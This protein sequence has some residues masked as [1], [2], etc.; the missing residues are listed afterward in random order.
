LAGTVPPPVTQFSGKT[1]IIQR[2]RSAV[3]GSSAVFLV[4]QWN[5][6]LAVEVGLASE[7]QIQ[8]A[9]NLTKKMILALGLVWVGAVNAQTAATSGSS[10]SGL[11]GQRYAELGFGVHD[12]KFSS[13]HLYGAAL[14]ANVPVVPAL[15]DANVSWEHDWMHGRFGGEG[16]VFAGTVTAYAPLR[17]VKPFLGGGLGW[18]TSGFGSDPHGLWG[19]SGGVE[20]AAGDFTVTPRV[21]YVDDF[22]ETR[23]ST[24]QWSWAVEGNYWIGGRTGLFASVGRSDVLRSPA[25]SWDYL[26]GVRMKF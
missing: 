16:D 14:A 2:R 5:P 19:V 25:R 15:L 21:S 7:I 9:M 22:E 20:I 1:E 24:Q 17:G 23:I 6:K 3:P 12:L 10:G 8:L 18:Q 4:R 13:H 11:L 26:V